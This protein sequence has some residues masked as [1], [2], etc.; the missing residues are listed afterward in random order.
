MV[1]SSENQIRALIRLLA[2][3]NE[4]IVKTISGKL[5]EIGD[6]AVPL[7]QEA[8]IEQPEMARR[9]EEILDEIRGSRLEDDLRTL[10]AYPD[11]RVD[12]E[13]GAF[14]IARYG[15]PNLDV[16]AYGRQL[17][18]MATEVRDRMGPRC[19]IGAP[20]FRSACRSSTCSWGGVSACR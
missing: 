19:S 2:D 16:Q 4:R 6:T 13:T 5:V 7:L 20:V 11:D 15:Y 18:T 8:E 3:E 14:L 10:A 1:G 17:D 12:L 9:I